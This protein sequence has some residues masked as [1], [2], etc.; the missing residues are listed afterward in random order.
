MDQLERAAEPMP[1][2]LTSAS[3][4]PARTSPSRACDARAAACAICWKSVTSSVSGCTRPAGAFPRALA[5][6]RRRARRR[7]PSSRRGQVQRGRLADARGGPGDQGGGHLLKAISRAGS[8][9]GLGSVSMVS[10][11]H[12]RWPARRCPPRGDRARGACRAGGLAALSGCGVEPARRQRRARRRGRDDARQPAPRPCC[13]RS[14]GWC[15]ASTAR[16]SPANARWRDALITRS[17]ALRKAVEA[18][19]AA[20]ARARRAR[21]AGDGPPDQP[22]GDASAGRVLADVGGPAV[23]PLRGRL[24]GRGGQADRE[25]QTSVWADAG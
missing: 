25:F 5:G 3:S 6:L 14:A 7:A 22:A 10:R 21:A 23:A 18:D 4:R 8:G 2:L 17:P 24:R 19:D 12:A 11:V 13:R 16:A 1:A 20:A 9:R 15:G